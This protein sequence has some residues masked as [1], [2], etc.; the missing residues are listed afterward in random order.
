MDF[1]ELERVHGGSALTQST[2]HL[3][4]NFRI[5]SL[6]GQGRHETPPRPLPLAQGPQGGSP[7]VVT[8][9]TGAAASTVTY[10]Y[11]FNTPG[12]YAVLNKEITGSGIVLNPNDINV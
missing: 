12:E 9:I 11:H 1:Q 10:T 7:G 4:Q 8:Q 3:T 2:E 5:P 6:L